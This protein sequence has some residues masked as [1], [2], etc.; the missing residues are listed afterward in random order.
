[1]L[2]YIFI[3]CVGMAGAVVI[4]N[5]AGAVDISDSAFSSNTASSS[6]GRIISLQNDDDN[7]SDIQMYLH[8][9]AHI[10][11]ECNQSGLLT[12]LLL[13]LY[14]M[15]CVLMTYM[16]GALSI[17]GVTGAVSIMSGSTFT[18]NLNSSGDGGMFR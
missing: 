11:K 3:T 14:C 7:D 17:A 4:S 12:L 5:I 10:L 18:G 13:L 8:V 9:C 16:T 6:G 1:M 15:T 2:L